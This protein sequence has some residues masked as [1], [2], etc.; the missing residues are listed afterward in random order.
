MRDGGLLVGFI[1]GLEDGGCSV[2]LTEILDVLDEDSHRD[3]LLEILVFLG[4]IEG[5][6]TTLH[7][8]L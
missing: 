8:T 1:E 4:D 2:L 7:L 3:L 5:G 6:L